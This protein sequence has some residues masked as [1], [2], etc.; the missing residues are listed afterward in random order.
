[1]AEFYRE[2]KAWIMPYT[3]QPREGEYPDGLAHSIHFA[4]SRDGVHF[5]GLNGNYGILFAK[6]QIGEDNTIIPKGVKNPFVFAMPGRK[7][8]ILAVR[9]R[10]NGSADTDSRGKVLLWITKDFTDFEEKG[11]IALGGQACVEWVRCAYDE[12]RGNY[13]VA[14]RTAD[15]EVFCRETADICHPKGTV[16]EC[17]PDRAGD[18]AECGECAVAQI[19]CGAVAGN[20]MEIAVSLHD[21]L[22]LFYGKL[23]NVGVRVPKRTVVRC[24]ADLEAVRATAVYSDGSTSCKRVNWECSGVD[25]ETPGVYRI[26][27]EV[28]NVQYRFPLAC[29]Y[30]DPVLFFWKGRWYFIATNDNLDDIGLYV[31]EAQ[32]IE[33]L[34]ADGVKEHLIL[35][36]DR[37]KGFV[38]TFW[39]PEFHVIGGKLYLLFAVSGEAWGPQCHL[40]ELKEGGSI[41]D[42]DGWN[43]P[44]RVRK[45]DG[46]WLA[47]DAITLDMT[48]I[49][50]GRRSYMVWSYRE[51][52]GTRADTGSMLYIASVR[53][54]T[55]WMLDSE[56]VL[57]SRPLYGWENVSHTINNEGPYAFLWQDRVY[58]TYSGGA[59]NGYTYVLGLLTARADADLTDASVWKKSFFPVLSFYS[60]EGEYGPGHNSF[61]TDPQG[62]L[63]IA[64][65]AE[66]SLQSNLRC[67]AVRRVHFDINERP[68]FDLSAERDFD[69]KLRRVETEV[70]VCP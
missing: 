37:E 2:K 32:D 68:V 23:Y 13:H 51:K 60:V 11:L 22:G 55:P 48:Y 29:G 61:F 47:E 39:A 20:R 24:P 3:R 44:V 43:V 15:G 42:P 7:F 6:A 52:I 66:D 46:S 9:T 49:K 59:A 5:E 4:V 53:E 31:R 1:M 18:S 16:R 30:G 64:Y 45:K 26:G 65:H 54:D 56:P 19:P 50:A 36:L 17:P 70:E 34:F 58:L 28:E 14:W 21:R 57:L 40:M 25:F 10:E 69:P 38:Q 62:N 67:D 63:M 35:G 8:G 12:S 41:T 33:G 27:G